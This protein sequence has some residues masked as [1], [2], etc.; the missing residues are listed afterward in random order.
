MTGSWLLIE[1]LGADR[2]PTLV[3]DGDRTGDRVRLL[4]V[5]R[6]LGST[7]SAR[8]AEVVGRVVETG[9]PEST[10]TA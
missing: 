7:V 9:G 1:T 3:A 2:E 5:R 4:R 6:E 8:V 10:L